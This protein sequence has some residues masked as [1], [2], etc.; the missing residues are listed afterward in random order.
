MCIQLGKK[1]CVKGKYRRKGSSGQNN[2]KHTPTSH[3]KDTHT[4]TTTHTESL[5]HLLVKNT[6]E[7]YTKT[8]FA[9]C[10]YHC[11]EMLEIQI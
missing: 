1:L 4:Q 9:V 10:S 5:I 7:T 3:A 6:R 2:I 8:V 11:T